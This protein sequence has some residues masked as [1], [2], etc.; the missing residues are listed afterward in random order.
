MANR[1]NS[2]NDRMTPG[3]G[4]TR[5]KRFKY[6]QGRKDAF[7]EVQYNSYSDPKV[8]QG[9]LF[10]HRALMN[11]PGNAEVKRQR[12]GPKGFSKARLDEVRAGFGTER[13]PGRGVPLHID[14]RKAEDWEK[15]TGYT[16][17]HGSYGDEPAHWMPNVQS[18]RHM[19]AP[20]HGIKNTRGR[21]YDEWTKKGRHEVLGT[22]ARST[23]P[24]EHL[25]GLSEI[26]LEPQHPDYG[27][28]Y[29]QA[30]D[31]ESPSMRTGARIKLYG[32]NDSESSTGRSDQEM[33]LMHELGHHWSHEHSGDYGGYSTPHEQGREEA[34]ADSYALRHYRQDPRNKAEYG[35]HYDP[36]EHTYGARGQDAK[37]EGSY[38]L[39]ARDTA[40]PHNP[41]LNVHQMASE[42]AQ[43]QPML[44]F[45]NEE[46]VFTQRPKSVTHKTEDVPTQG[47]GTSRA[48]QKTTEAAPWLD[49]VPHQEA[50]YRH[51]AFRGQ[52]RTN[53]RDEARSRQEVSKRWSVG[54]QFK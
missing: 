6:G 10:S 46:A 47:G 53:R 50:I 24:A 22:L 2:K 8:S 48:W 30:R 14:Q 34:R 29:H 3:F 54:S 52:Q 18:D 43:Q 45:H 32:G 19:Y 27:G 25:K 40:L 51:E 35:V 16:H 12:V 7:G 37:F 39:A 23:M 44:D 13:Q 41:N 31:H 21:V 15:G 9:T 5:E 38:K 20:E 49:K 26:R 36:R 4:P 33:T 1:K 11:L 28:T 42:Q 17:E